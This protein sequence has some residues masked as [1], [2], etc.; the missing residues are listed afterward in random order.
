MLH[1]RHH[2]I[3]THLR[4]DH[5]SQGDQASSVLSLGT[6]LNQMSLQTLLPVHLAVFL[7]V[8]E[9]FL[10]VFLQHTAAKSKEQ[11]VFIEKVDIILLYI[12]CRTVEE[13]ALHLST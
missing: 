9:S 13:R 4:Q 7:P 6:F 8:L 2:Q 3:P 5:A 12:H 1:H 10:K 11:T